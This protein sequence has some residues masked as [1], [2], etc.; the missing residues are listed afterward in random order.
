[1]KQTVAQVEAPNSTKQA[2]TRRGASSHNKK[3]TMIQSRTAPFSSQLY[4]VSAVGRSA[5]LRTT[6]LSSHVQLQLFIN[7]V[8][9]YNCEKFFGSYSFK[10]V[11]YSV[12]LKSQFLKLVCSEATNIKSVFFCF[13]FKGCANQLIGV[14]SLAFFVIFSKN[15]CSLTHEQV[16]S[17]KKRNHFLLKS[18]SSTT[19]RIFAQYKIQLQTFYSA[20]L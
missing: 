10:I 11:I 9:S 18:R 1:M 13:K 16:R 7:E 8:I 2:R 20:L 14:K 4:G 6:L 12:Q 15:C 3:I 19:D 17:S 5:G